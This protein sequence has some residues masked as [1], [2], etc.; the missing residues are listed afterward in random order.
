MKNYEHEQVRKFVI[1][2]AL[3]LV[4]IIDTCA[5][6][7]F[8]SRDPTS[9]GAASIQK[10]QRLSEA[11]PPR[12][13]LEGG[14]GIAFGIDSAAIE[15]QTGLHPMNLGLYAGFGMDFMDA[16][17]Q[18]GAHSGDILLIVPEYDFLD[19]PSSAQGFIVLEAMQEDPT[20]IR[21]AWS[22]PYTLIDI[23]RQFPG[24]FST[25]V[26]SLIGKT[27]LGKPLVQE[28]SLYH[29]VYR[30]SS[31]NVYGDM[32]GHLPET[33]HL[34]TSTVASS[35]V[36]TEDAPNAD[37]LK[38]LKT[39]ID[40]EQKK[41]VTVLVSWPAV[42]KSLYEENRDAI[43]EQ[44]SLLVETVGSQRILGT[45]ADFTFDDSDFF[46][47]IGHLDA[48]GREIRTQRLIELMKRWLANNLGNV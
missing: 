19:A 2:V 38:S 41:S 9:Y 27:P 36:L 18:S 24:W 12:L 37:T 29:R 25:R 1:E 35:S 30:A 40:S 31:F 20:F 13:I 6:I 46:D 11:P 16:Q 21:F 47:S 23:V 28:N 43:L 42:P 3:C 44:D 45:Q 33:Y 34:S 7:L 32:V 22:N 48:S 8:I 5:C 4:I 17:A 26:V 10:M 15:K 39:F 14:S